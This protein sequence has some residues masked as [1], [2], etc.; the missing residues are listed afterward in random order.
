MNEK[1]IIIRYFDKFR[2]EILAKL[3]CSQVGE[4]LSEK[5]KIRLAQAY[6]DIVSEG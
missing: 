4:V 5:E 6:L 2:Y 1:R 3:N